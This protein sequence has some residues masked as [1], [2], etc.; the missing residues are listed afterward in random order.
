MK[1]PLLLVLSAALVSGC[2]HTHETVINDVSR[3]AVE[4]ENDAAARDFYEAISRLPNGGQ[5]QESKTEI[6]IPIVFEHERKVVRGP[7][8]AF[9]QAVNRCDTNRDG[10]ISEA[11]ARIFGA[12][13]R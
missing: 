11:E 8:Q 7:N 1:I 13:V 5:Q 4:F 12:T 2:I 10:K 3:T 6:S 9:N